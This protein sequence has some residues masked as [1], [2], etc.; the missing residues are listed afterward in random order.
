MPVVV[1][2]LFLILELYWLVA[3]LVMLPMMLMMIRKTVLTLGPQ[4]IPIPIEVTMSILPRDG[5]KLVPVTKSLCWD[6]GSTRLNPS[7]GGVQRFRLPGEIKL[8]ASGWACSPHGLLIGVLEF[9]RLSRIGWLPVV[10]VLHM[11]RGRWT[12][13]YGTQ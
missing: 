13:V 9:G 5:V 2:L 8:L 12:H 1:V 11:E 4:V 3:F 10:H 6:L 7:G